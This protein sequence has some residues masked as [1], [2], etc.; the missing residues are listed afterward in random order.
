MNSDSATRRE[1]DRIKIFHD[2]GLKQADALQR[3]A[4]EDPLTREEMLD[5]LDKI[6]LATDKSLEFPAQLRLE[7]ADDEY[8]ENDEFTKENALEVLER[9]KEQGEARPTT[10]YSLAMHYFDT[11]PNKAL[12]TL[13][14][15]IRDGKENATI[16]YTMFRLRDDRSVVEKLV[17]ITEDESNEDWTAFQALLGIYRTLELE[18]DP[19]QPLLKSLVEKMIR[20]GVFLRELTTYIVTMSRISTFGHGDVG[21]LAVKESE[22]G[23]E[24]ENQIR[25]LSQGIVRVPQ[26]IA[27]LTDGQKQYYV[28]EFANGTTLT[29]LIK[30]KEMREE[31]YDTALR[32]LAK[33]NVQTTREGFQNYDY[34]TK[35][36][37]HATAFD[38]RIVEHIEVVTNTIEK[39]RRCVSRDPHTDNLMILE[40]ETVMFL[41]TADKG[42]ATY[43]AEA[44]H[45][46][47][48]IP[49]YKTMDEKVE[50]AERYAE[51]VTEE[52]GEVEESFEHEFLA[53][54]IARS[55]DK[56]TYYRKL[57]RTKDHQNAIREGKDALDYLIMNI[58]L[59]EEE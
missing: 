22:E 20:K 1:I 47:G 42:L 9:L 59:S 45:L 26:A 50:A 36:R 12:T 52:G 41:D 32:E 34:R 24:R 28:M 23:F 53:A 19:T 11:N 16:L 51:Y 5:G 6:I 54:T 57:G 4:E 38:T 39:G 7:E 43:A 31:G 58:P 33:A 48:F 44:A 25:R 35:A 46:I 13:E 15:A 2:E 27:R 37:K 21:T 40:D 18:E 10:Y 3:R 55:M 56:A 17:A 49:Y 14:E 30:A 8:G 29:E